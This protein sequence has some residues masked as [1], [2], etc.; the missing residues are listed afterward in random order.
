MIRDCLM[1]L[2]FVVYRALRLQR[3]FELSR[4]PK[5][6]PGICQKSNLVAVSEPTRAD[7]RL[8]RERAAIASQDCVWVGLL[9]RPNPH[10]KDTPCSRFDERAVRHQH[11]TLVRYRAGIIAEQQTFYADPSSSQ[12]SNSRNA[13][14]TPQRWWEVLTAGLQHATR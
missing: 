11:L 12:P 3:R 13:R 5:D 7:R 2:V 14:I 9:P 4:K 6:N 10:V 1:I 8:F